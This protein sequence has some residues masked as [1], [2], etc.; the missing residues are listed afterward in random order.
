[1]TVKKLNLADKLAEHFRYKAAGRRNYKLSDSLL[2]YLEAH[3]VPGDKITIPAGKY[4]GTYE[5]HDKGSSFNVG[6]TARR[7]EF[8]EVA[9]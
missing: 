5:F 3:L 1:M 4:A 2:N 9:E 6:Q 7:F 8:R